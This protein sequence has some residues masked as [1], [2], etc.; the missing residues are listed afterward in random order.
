VTGY[1]DKSSES[2]HGA[3]TPFLRFS[4]WLVTKSE[5]T[6][7]VREGRVGGAGPGFCTRYQLSPKLDAGQGLFGNRNKRA[8]LKI[9]A[10]S[11]TRNRRSCYDV[12]HLEECDAPSR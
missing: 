4:L 10:S 3:A 8:A 7:I 11:M 6:S 2:S 9:L 1:E 5:Q 12:G